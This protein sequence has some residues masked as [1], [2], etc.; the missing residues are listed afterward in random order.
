[1]V[2]NLIRHVS[3][4]SKNINY[5][6]QNIKSPIRGTTSAPTKQDIKASSMEGIGE[7]KTSTSI[8]ETASPLIKQSKA[9]GTRSHYKSAWNSFNSWCSER[10]VNPISCSL[11]II[12]NYLG[13]LFEKGREYCTINGHRS[14]ISAFHQAI[15]GVPVGQHPSVTSLMKGVSRERPPKPKYVNI[16]EVEQSLRS[17]QKDA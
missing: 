14:A 11:E 5:G 6:P 3:S 7:G 8:S 13:S 12:L 15:E 17:I 16:W 9:L 1:M 2:S 10:K 4:E